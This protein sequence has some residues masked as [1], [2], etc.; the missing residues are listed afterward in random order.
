MRN[1]AGRLAPDAKAGKFLGVHADF[2]KHYNED[3]LRSLG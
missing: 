1:F 2:G 3:S